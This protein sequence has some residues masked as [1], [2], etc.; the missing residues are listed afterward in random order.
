MAK[1]KLAPQTLLY[2]NPA[3]IIGANVDGKPNFMT[4]AWC[5]VACSEPPMISVGIRP[6]RYTFGG[7]R[8]NMTFS[9]SI[10]SANLVA[11]TDY[12]GIQSGSEADK[13]KV[14]GFK[15]FYGKTATAPL[16]EECPVNLDCRVVHILDLGSHAL[17]V[18]R[19]EDTYVSEECLTDGK[20][21]AAKI[22]PFA[23]VGG[24]YVT[25]GESVGKAFGAGL[26]LKKKS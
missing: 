14:C 26:K 6:S 7:I 23:F 15:V 3:V 16:I 19:I 13:A 2:P 20:P 5:G 21:D 4:A 11:E 22:K 24:Q 10:A 18:G 25:M 17:I 9:V 12:C 1:I 8:Q